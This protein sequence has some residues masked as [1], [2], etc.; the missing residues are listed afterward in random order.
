MAKGFHPFRSG[1]EQEC[2]TEANNNNNNTGTTRDSNM[3]ARRSA[4]NLPLSQMAIPIYTAPTR[5]DVELGGR[6]LLQNF[7]HEEFEHEGLPDDVLEVE[8]HQPDA[9]GDVGPGT[10]ANLR[11]GATSPS[12]AR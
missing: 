6:L 4:L 2:H 7:I 8:N 9:F 1:S 12:M 3:L 11:H 10:F 5:E